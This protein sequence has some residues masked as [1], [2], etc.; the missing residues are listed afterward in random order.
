ME[1][2][3]G[4]QT[5]S[6]LVG[7]LQSHESVV[8][9]ITSDN[10]SEFARHEEVSQALNAE[11]FFAHPYSSWECGLNEN[12][13]GLVRQYI[14]KGAGLDDVTNE[15]LAIIADKLNERPRK[16]LGFKTPMEVFMNR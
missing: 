9:T 5:K 3:T 4:E 1:A 16:T 11:F 7:A 14:K 8:F 15:Y 2:K 13:N 6:A 10:G 12:I